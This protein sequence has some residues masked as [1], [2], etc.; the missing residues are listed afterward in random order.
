MGGDAGRC[1]C[2][3]GEVGL[4]GW[5]AA[6]ASD[7]LDLKGKSERGIFSISGDEVKCGFGSA[8]KTHGQRGPRLLA[9]AYQSHQG[10]IVKRGPGSAFVSIKAAGLADR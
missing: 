4:P 5:A 3:A 1:A 6:G 2:A 10:G 7:I 8:P 9:M